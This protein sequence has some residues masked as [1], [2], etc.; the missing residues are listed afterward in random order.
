M[1]TPFTDNYDKKYLQENMMGP[2]AMRIAEEL[3]DGLGITPDSKILDLGCGTGLTSILL[4]QKYG[5]SVFAA[6]LWIAPTDNARRFEER[7]MDKQIIPLR[8]DATKEIPFAENYFDAILSVDAYQYFGCDEVMLPKLLPFLKK[9]GKIA[10][11]VP[12]FNQDF[13]EGNLPKEVAQF[14]T[15]EWHFYSL[16]WWKN[17]W[18]KAPG[19]TVTGA[20]EMP[21]CKQAWDEWLESPSEFARNDQKMMDAGAGKH[22]SLIQLVAEKN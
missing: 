4:A 20:L 7:G 1:A 6:D 14:W 22:F 10:V 2:N 17:L 21:C 12:G 9:G 15:P 16:N 11:A 3:A 18:S 8:F 13:P 5:A 19:I